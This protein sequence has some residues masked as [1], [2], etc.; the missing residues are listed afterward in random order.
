MRRSDRHGN[1]GWLLDSG[2]AP[3]AQQSCR[4][5]RKKIE[6]QDV[7]ENKAVQHPGVDCQHLLGMRICL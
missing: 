4:E 3:D 5:G 1:G 7:H 6:I 2:R